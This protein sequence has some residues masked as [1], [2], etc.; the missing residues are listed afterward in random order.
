LDTA[1]QEIT[2][3]EACTE[4]KLICGSALHFANVG[5]DDDAFGS[6]ITQYGSIP[7]N[8]ELKIPMETG[9]QDN[10]KLLVGVQ[11]G[12]GNL[13]IQPIIWALVDD[14]IEAK[15]K[16]SDGGEKITKEERQ[17]IILDNLLDIP[18]KIE[19]LIKGL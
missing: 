11:S 12:T 10:K 1:A 15:D 3:P 16:E 19:P 2:L 9:R 13:T 7:A 14:I 5:N 8:H 17:Q 18:A 4:I 6:A